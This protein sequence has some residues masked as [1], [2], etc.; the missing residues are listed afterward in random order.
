[1]LPLI[2]FVGFFKVYVVLF[3]HLYG[4]KSIFYSYKLAI[5]LEKW[6]AL[7]LKSKAYLLKTS[8]SEHRGISKFTTI[9]QVEMLSLKCTLLWVF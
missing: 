4:L 1:M 6:T 2:N 5:L 3:I 8:T 7:Y 9:D